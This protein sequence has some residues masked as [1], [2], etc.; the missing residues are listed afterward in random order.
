[1]TVRTTDGPAYTGR[2]AGGLRFFAATV[3]ARREVTGA[4]VR[5]AQGTIIGI[6]ERGIP[7]RE[8]RRRVLAERG[9]LGVQLVRRTGD[10]PCLTAFAADLPPARR[11]CTDLDPGIPIDG[12]FLP[13]SA[14]VTVP[15]SPR[16]RARLRPHGRPVRHPGRAAGRRPDG[17]RSRI[18]LRG[19]DAF[20]AFLPDARVRGLR[21]GDHRVALDLPP[22]SAQCGY[23][24]SR[25]F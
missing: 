1:M 18:S 2:W 21:S 24:A 23:S 5:N 16:E 15:C 10:P 20:V 19:E 12:P 17:A 7:R 25:G 11:Y 4:V 14:T 13:Y 3:P 22:A 9:G 6:N 8:V